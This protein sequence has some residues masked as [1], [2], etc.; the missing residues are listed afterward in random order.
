[1]KLQGKRV[2]LVGAGHAHLY[3][4]AHAS[5]L[6]R[7]GAGLVLV[8][9][10]NFWYSGLATGM[11]AGQYDAEADQV[12]P[13]RLVERAGG[14]FVRDRLT[15]ID[16]DR[17][18]AVLAS[19]NTLQYD[20]L[21]L[22]IGSEVKA[23]D[24]P[25]AERH[26]WCVKPIRNLWRLRQHVEQRFAEPSHLPLRVTV[27]GGGPT[28][29]EVAACIDALARRRGAR[30][31]LTLVSRSDRLLAGLPSGA[32]RRLTTLLARRGIDVLPSWPVEQIEEDAV[33]RAGG[34]RL[35]GD[36]AVLATGLTAPALLRRLALPL[37]ADDGVRVRPTLQSVADDRI[38]A[39]GDCASLE[40]HRLPKLGVF[41]VR[42]GPVLLHNLRALLHG[43]EL[44][45]YIPQRRCLMI[46]NLGCGRALAVSG[47]AQRVG[48][49]G[50]L[51]KD[52]IDRRFLRQYSQPAD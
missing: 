33:I 1:M 2:V 23:C 22:N 16:A 21:S 11:L 3:V 9:P 8:D 32:V 49:F 52:H 12:D 7:D 5:V 45:R 26:A 15:E 42:Q 38:F 48:G 43:T 25:G 19:G 20:A 10:G 50:V 39:A 27:V 40:G 13:A 46:L 36:V 37:D 14:E 35:P 30:V 4:V 47:R 28:G 44:R 6:T 17:Q 41:G 51:V 31:Q 24:L 29:C 18:T 34:R